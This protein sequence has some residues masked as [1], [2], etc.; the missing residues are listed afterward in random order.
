MANQPVFTM[1]DHGSDFASRESAAAIFPRLRDILD[2][3]PAG[4]KV[5][6]DWSGITPTPSFL[7]E[8]ISLL[9]AEEGGSLLDRII[10]V[11]S[12]KSITNQIHAI[13]RHR[14]QEQG[15]RHTKTLDDAV[16]GRAF[17]WLGKLVMGP[18]NSST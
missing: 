15:V 6:V 7:D 8:F 11:V 1:A 17:M 2:S 5:I 13:L 18:G 16:S 9:C 3:Q 10:F 12:D 14:K 4:A